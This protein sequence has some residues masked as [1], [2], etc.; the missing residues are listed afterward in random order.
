MN[1]VNPNEK[2]TEL[3]IH[4]VLV[5]NQLESE[6]VATCE[7]A[8]SSNSAVTS[9][10]GDTSIV[11]TER[12]RTLSVVYEAPATSGNGA[13]T[14]DTKRTRIGHETKTTE[15]EQTSSSVVYETPIPTIEIVDVKTTV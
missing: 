15:N 13:V 11:N 7:D 6:T 1:L 14:S 10:G 2:N 3:S 9:V 12:K 8:T 4:K 5:H